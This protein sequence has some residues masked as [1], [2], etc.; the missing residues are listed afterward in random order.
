METKQIVYLKYLPP[1]LA[2]Y[3]CLKRQEIIDYFKEHLLLYYETSS[4]DRMIKELLPA[5]KSMLKLYRPPKET[6]SSITEIL[7]RSIFQPKREL[8]PCELWKLLHGLSELINNKC[9]FQFTLPWESVMK[10]LEFTY[11]PNKRSS[12]IM[13]KSEIRFSAENLD[14]VVTG[15]R[16]C[17]PLDSGL[18]IYNYIKS[19]L[20]PEEFEKRN[21][22]S[23]LCTL[24]RTDHQV[25]KEIY[26]PWM[27]DV[28]TLLSWGTVNKEFKIYAFNLLAN[29]KEKHYEINWDPYI[30]TLFQGVIPICIEG[31]RSGKKEV[32]QDAAAKLIIFL[33]QPHPEGK[34]RAY[35]Y[36]EQILEMLKFGLYPS[37][38]DLRVEKNSGSFIEAL[39]YYV[40]YRLK[41]ESHCKRIKEEQK[42]TKIDVYQFV[43]LIIE[44]LEPTLLCFKMSD[45]V[46]HTLCYLGYLNPVRVLDHY[47]PKLLAVLDDYAITHIPALEYLYSL[48]SPLLLTSESPRRFL[49]LK[50]IIN[51]VLREILTVDSGTNSVPLCIIGNILYEIPLPHSNFLKT[52][53]KDS[54]YD[55]ILK[56]LKKTNEQAFYYHEL[57]NGMEEQVNNLLD[58]VFAVAETMPKPSKKDNSR[59]FIDRV[60]LI[61]KS[62]AMNST[63]NMFKMVLEK[64]KTFITSR[65]ND[66]CIPEI[67]EIIYHFCLRD[68]EAVA[69]IIFPYAFKN[70]LTKKTDTK[71][72]ESLLGQYIKTSMNEWYDISNKYK[73]KEFITKNAFEYYC[74]LIKSVMNIDGSAYN[75]Y[76]EEVIALIVLLILDKDKKRNNIATKLIDQLLWGKLSH[77]NRSKYLNELSKWKNPLESY[78]AIGLFNEEMVEV[79]WKPMTKTN[80]EDAKE[81]IETLCFKLGQYVLD[82]LSKDN[83]SII[84]TWLKISK[85]IGLDW[86]DIIRKEGTLTFSS[87]SSLLQQIAGKEINDYFLTLRRRLLGLTIKIVE[88]VIP[89]IDTQ[90]TP[91]L[92]K[93]LLNSLLTS[94]K[95]VNA[96][97]NNK[98]DKAL[99]LKRYHSALVKNPT[100][101]TYSV[102][103]ASYS[104]KI[105]TIQRDIAKCFEKSNEE[106]FVEFQRAFEC[107]LEL[108]KHVPDMV[109]LLSI[110]ESGFC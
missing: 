90:I 34:C 80:L 25:P 43:E 1:Y 58:K 12:L 14:K 7:V 16:K 89:F 32:S 76:K 17:L 53:Y 73:L 110:I 35:E 100:I 61:A 6:V 41:L 40:C 97:S 106:P 69:D 8:L 22:Q 54:N 51:K 26:E 108:Y 5:I 13:S 57:L 87:V 50:N 23:H 39:V 102:N 9:K 75:R 63:D 37:S 67:S 28:L 109:I 68:P 59:S 104:N 38:R 31:I 66:N 70:L 79:Q 10:L 55:H 83:D 52:L 18:Q 3:Y 84:V 93:N 21:Y 49:Y 48:V 56:E 19:F 45:E 94:I 44:V 92:V 72:W 62:I 33:M 101:K 42:L 60:S 107:A 82:T 88:K 91:R 47:V 103:Y 96:K 105:W 36:T 99:A 24:L 78:K 81:I 64:F 98:N 11:R 2:E 86:F 30:D 85:S 4:Y 27:K 46:L 29:L 15:I 95:T 77:K 65:I 74:E 20:C 71:L